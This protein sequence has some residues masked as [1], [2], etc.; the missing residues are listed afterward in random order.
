[1]GEKPTAWLGCMR[2]TGTIVEDI[3]S[4]SVDE[5]KVGTSEIEAAAIRSHGCHRMKETGHNRKRPMRDSERGFLEYILKNAATGLKRWKQ[6]AGNALV[7]WAVSMLGL[8]LVWLFVAWLVRLIF[9]VKIGWDS[10]VAIWVVFLGTPACAFYAVVSSVR[11]L[12]GSRDVLPLVRADLDAGVVI[13]EFY[14]FA[15]AKRFQEPEHGG[16]IY[17]LK[18]TDNKVLVLYDHESA[19]LGARDENPFDSDFKPRIDLLMV[20]APKTGYVISREFSGKTLDA[21]DPKELAIKPELWPETEECCD[22]PWDDLE[23]RLSRS[24]KQ[25]IK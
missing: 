21:G 10:P 15:A 12:R 18:T 1:M 8:V 6:G 25:F 7:L 11:W 2:G 20:R 9:H 19:N 3:I 24:N 5:E 23:R 13:E 14:R 16:L 17:F 22:I 4:S